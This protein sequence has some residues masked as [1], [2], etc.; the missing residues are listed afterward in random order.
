MDFLG[1]LGVGVGDLLGIG[2]IGGDGVGMGGDGGGGWE[3][4]FDEA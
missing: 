1:G 4:K 3:L 2:G